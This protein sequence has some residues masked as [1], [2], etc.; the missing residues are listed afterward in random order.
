[1]YRGGEIK[2]ISLKFFLLEKNIY[3]YMYIKKI[4][5]EGGGWVGGGGGML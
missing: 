4:S 2:K 3:I 1:M 5:M